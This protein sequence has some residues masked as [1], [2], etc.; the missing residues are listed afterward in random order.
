MSTDSDNDDRMFSVYTPLRNHLRK[1]KLIDSLQAIHYHILLQQFN[2]PLPS[3]IQAPIGYRNARGMKEFIPF[4][5]APWEIEVIAKEVIINSPKYGAIKSLAEWHQFSQVA[6]KLKDLEEKASKLYATKE[7][8]LVELH[9]IAH[10]QFTWQH[11]PTMGDIGQYWKIYS[12]P[13]LAK[14]VEKALGLSVDKLFMISMAML[15][16]FINHFL[17]WYPPQINIEGLNASDLDLYLNHFS[18]EYQKLSSVLKTE[19]EMNQKYAYAYNSLKAYPIIKIAVD[20]RVGLICPV[21]TLLFRRIT[22][23]I[24]YE[25]CNADKFNVLF[26][27]AFQNY[28]GGMLKNSN[29][30]AIL[31]AEEKYGKPEKRTTDWIFGDNGTLLFVECKS[32]RLTMEAKINLT[33]LKEL[34]KQLDILA[35]GI[36]QIYKSIND[37][38]SNKFPQLKYDSKVKIYPVIVTLEEWFLFGDVLVAKLDNFIKARLK[39]VGLPGKM[40]VNYPY[41]VSSVGGLN[42]LATASSMVKIDDILHEKTTDKDKRMWHLD[43]YLQNRYHN[44]LESYEVYGKKEFD[45]FIESRT[46]NKTN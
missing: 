35:E 6:N 16:S 17:L 45:E 26:G 14:L 43:T 32:K 28:I 22:E 34:E 1:E 23:G 18:K 3:F 41:V 44:E 20:G 27:N 40:L 25:I 37:Y 42:M 10:R 24:Y 31:L 7:N 15:G 13:D 38:N 2:K 8:V 30:K 12:N 11:Q 39:G 46:K 19:L 36:V 33:D 21:L 5:I 4:H 29:P 9:R